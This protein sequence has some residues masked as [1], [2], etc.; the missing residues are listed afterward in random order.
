MKA[1]AKAF[2]D[3]PVVILGTLQLI[4]AGLGAYDYVAPV[5]VFIG[6]GVITLLQKTLVK[7]DPPASAP[8]SQ[9]GSAELE[10]L[11][12]VLGIVLAVLVSYPLGIVCIAVGLVLL[13]WPRISRGSR[14]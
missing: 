12:I 1:I 13:V 6:L 11:L 8:Q 5:V 4:I 14:V 2:Y 9:A 10:L 7:P 3:N